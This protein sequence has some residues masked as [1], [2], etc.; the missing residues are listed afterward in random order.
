MIYRSLELNLLNNLCEF[1]LLQL[2]VCAIEVGSNVSGL[3]KP[4][5]GE[6][7]GHWF[8]RRA[9]CQKIVFARHL[10]HLAGPSEARRSAIIR[11]ACS[12][13]ELSLRAQFLGR[14][15]QQFVP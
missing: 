10:I 12:T 8:S 5:P 7:N 15:S 11:L 3:R 9:G 14:D 4:D 1:R 13:R 6:S 2:L